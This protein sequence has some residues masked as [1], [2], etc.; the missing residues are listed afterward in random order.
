MI[1]LYRRQ[2]DVVVAEVFTEGNDLPQDVIWIDA[3][4]PTDSELAS[5]QKQMGIQ[6]PSK[7]DVWKNQIL[8]RLYMRNGVAYMTAAVIS[9]VDTPYPE[10]SAITF[11]LKQDALLTIRVISPTSFKEFAHR[12]V[13]PTEKFPTAAHVLEGLLEEMIDR[14]SHNIEIVED[15]LDIVSHRIFGTDAYEG[16]AQ[17]P[18]EL[19]KSVLKQMGVCADLNSKINESLHSINRLLHFFKQTV[20]EAQMLG[21]DVDILIA[22][23][24]VLTRQTDFAAEKIAFQLDATLGMINVEQN[25]IIKMFSVVAVFFMP[26]TLVASIYGMN[27]KFMPELEWINGYPMAISL[28]VLC[29]VVPYLYFRKKGWL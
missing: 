12:I 29:A 4:R 7:D 20:P 15:M 5:L 18:S 17:N 11:V 26:P 3:D 14:V 22:D 28:M 25:V 19:M 13:S 2:D 6:L 23:T 8:N 1:T 16:K 9:K 27:F 21:R 24:L 10:G